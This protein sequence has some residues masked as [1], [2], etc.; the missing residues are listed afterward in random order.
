MQRQASQTTG[1]HPHASAL[2]TWSQPIDHNEKDEIHSGLKLAYQ[3]LV[4]IYENNY[5]QTPVDH[6]IV[7]VSAHRD[8]R[9]GWG[10]GLTYS[11]ALPNRLRRASRWEGGWLADKFID[12]PRQ[13]FASRAKASP[14]WGRRGGVWFSLSPS[15]PLVR[16]GTCLPQGEG[17]HAPQHGGDF[18]FPYER[19]YSA[20]RY[21][22]SLIGKLGY[23]EYQPGFRR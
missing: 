19:M 13:C 9:F 10:F 23:S 17:S 1:F 4:N 5:L 2:A 22:I 8:K 20:K 12:F 15:L 21:S 3:E 11:P 16:S 18:L 7:S 6:H 14:P